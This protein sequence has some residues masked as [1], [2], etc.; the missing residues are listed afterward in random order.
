MGFTVHKVLQKTFPGMLLS[1]LLG[2]WSHSLR[3]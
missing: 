1:D 3:L 2:F